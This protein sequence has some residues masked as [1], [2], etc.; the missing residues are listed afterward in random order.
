M[1]RTICLLLSF[2]LIF[3]YAAFTANDAHGQAKAFT[4]QEM[5]AFARTS[6]QGYVKDVLTEKNVGRY[7]FS[8]VGEAS[9]A[10]LGDPLRV[11]SIELKELKGYR[12]GAGLR[13]MQADSRTTWYPVIANNEVRAKLEIIE[14]AGKLL[15]GGFGAASEAR[16]I[17]A[18]RQQI[19]NLL[20][21]KGIQ[22]PGAMAIMKIP[23]LKATFIF[24]ES[25]GGN[26][27]VPA[28]A[29]PQRFGVNNG[30]LYPAD[31]LLL[32]MKE[33]VKDLP[34]DLVG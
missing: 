28:M 15:A 31:E 32:R 7:G 29:S 21:A 14:T 5:G 9:A 25:A 24:V 8:T 23:A 33:Q 1:N 6:L 17:S 26:F 27:L 20:R 2:A 13:S 10:T 30:E 4:D 16:R 34:D 18:A 12:P 3:A 22:A 19:P 11:H